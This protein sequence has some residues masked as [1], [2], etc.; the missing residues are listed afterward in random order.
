[1]IE[2]F[3]PAYQYDLLSKNLKCLETKLLNKKIKGSNYG[4]AKLARKEM[5]IITN[6][7]KPITE[8]FFKK[9]I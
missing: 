7:L 5:L 9:E 6:H 1:M 4:Y 8:Y 3:I 2:N